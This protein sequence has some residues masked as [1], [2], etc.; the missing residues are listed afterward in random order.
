MEISSRLLFLKEVDLLKSIHRQTLLHNG[1]RLENSAEHS[2]HLAM[3]V[4]VCKDLAEEKI[5]LEK[6]LTMAILHDVVEIDA[7]D[8][9]VYAE[10]PL[11][12]EK[13]LAALERIFG[14]LPEELAN[15]LKAVWIEFENKQ[16]PEAKFVSALDRFLPMYSNFLNEGFTWKKHSITT[17]QVYSKN[18]KPIREGLPALWETAKNMVELSKEK[19]YLL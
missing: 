6:A 17:E 16:S 15:E 9:I 3:A 8:T 1:N 5:D 19:K 2:W 12:N 10:Q 18:E 14:L 13:E 11:K 7:G 4:L